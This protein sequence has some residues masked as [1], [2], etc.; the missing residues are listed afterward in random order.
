MCV[1]SNTLLTLCVLQVPSTQITNSCYIMTPDVFSCQYE[2]SGVHYKIV[3]LTTQRAKKRSARELGDSDD[4]DCPIGE[5]FQ[6][7]LVFH[8]LDM[9]DAKKLLVF[10]S[11]LSLIV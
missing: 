2:T 8:S 5:L 3:A 6:S 1:C 11:P 10:G 9:E 7:I 4:E